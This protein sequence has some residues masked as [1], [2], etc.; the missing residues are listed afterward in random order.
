MAENIVDKEVFDTFFKENYCEVDYK[1]IKNDFEEVTEG[2][3]DWLFTDGTDYKKLTEKNFIIYLRSAAYGEFEAIVEEAFDA[4]NPEIMDAVMD[5]SMTT[6]NEDEITAVYWDT[7]DALLKKFL[8]ELFR[9][10][11]CKMLQ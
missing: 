4:I 5:I 7:C 3:L 10:K 9:T 1:S 6:E 2:G 8:K 11:I